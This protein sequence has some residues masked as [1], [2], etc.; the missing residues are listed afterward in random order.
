MNAIPAVEKNP[1]SDSFE[2][3]G[4]AFPCERQPADRAR[5][6]HKLGPEQSKLEREHRAR[7]RTRGEENSHSLGPGFGEVQINQ[8]FGFEPAP[9]GNR[10]E[11]RH[12]DADRRED[13]VKTQ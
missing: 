5:V 4:R 10:H 2:K 13:D 6:F 11:E 1:E 8:L 7:D 3:K 12:R 9:M